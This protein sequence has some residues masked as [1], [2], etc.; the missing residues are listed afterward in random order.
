MLAYG[1]TKYGA[2]GVRFE[3]RHAFGVTRGWRLHAKGCRG[4][5]FQGLSTISSSPEIRAGTSNP[6]IEQAMM[7]PANRVFPC[8]APNQ[9]TD[10]GRVNQTDPLLDNLE[11]ETPGTPQTV[12]TKEIGGRAL[13]LKPPSSN[14]QLL[15]KMQRSYVLTRSFIE[16]PVC[17]G[18]PGSAE[19]AILR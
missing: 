17:S 7:I 5:P 15:R 1:R 16:G 4:S 12:V 13:C 10:W 9:V 6:G 18:A 19:S 11:K 2:C 3:D 8:P 14:L